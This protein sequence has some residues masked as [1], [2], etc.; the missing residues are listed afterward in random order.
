MSGR[1]QSENP[2]TRAAGYFADL[3]EKLHA[4]PAE[5]LTLD[6]I[7]AHALEVVPAA[8]S[9][10]ITLRRRRGRLETVVASDP[11]V[12]RCDQLQYEL[13]EG[14]CVDAANDHGYFLVRDTSTDQRWPTWGPRAAELGMRSLIAVQLS[15]PQQD[16]PDSVLGAINIYDGRIGTFS[17]D[18]LDQA[19]I[20]ASHAAD[21]LS[22]ARIIGGLRTAVHSRHL[23]GVAQGILMQRYGL[24]LDRAFDALRRYSNESNIKLSALAEMVVQNR[25][26]PEN[27]QVAEP[28]GR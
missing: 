14:P 22:S 19:I 15:A 17:P 9:C 3:A 26:M 4:Q 8:T 5:D 7:C 23:I 16:D 13:G 24:S 6:R 25:Q 20:F 12:T 10:G 27:G 18:D 21:A 1:D 28:E 11:V 2:A